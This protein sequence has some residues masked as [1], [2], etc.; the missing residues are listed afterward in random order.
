MNETV[1]FISWPHVKASKQVITKP[2]VKT[3]RILSQNYYGFDKSTQTTL[4]IVLQLSWLRL[5]KPKH[6]AILQ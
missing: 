3:C 1:C 6:V 4:H 2:D 5:F